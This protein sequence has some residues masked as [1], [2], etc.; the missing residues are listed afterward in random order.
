MNENQMLSAIETIVDANSLLLISLIRFHIF[1]KDKVGSNSNLLGEADE[2]R[3]EPW[4]PA[5]ACSSREIKK[6]FGNLG[7]ITKKILS[8]STQ[9]PSFLFF[10]HTLALGKSYLVLK[11]IY[12]WN[13]CMNIFEEVK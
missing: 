9:L 5:S 10:T 4:R 2:G 12:R 8:Q 7:I 11:H 1:R 6:N 13:T 3:I